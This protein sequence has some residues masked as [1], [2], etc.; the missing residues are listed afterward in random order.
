MDHLNFFNAPLS[1]SK[2]NSIMFYIQYF[3]RDSQIFS[4]KK[5]YKKY[6]LI[7]AINPS[8]IIFD[9]FIILALTV[10]RSK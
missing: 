4:L 10:L 8:L 9:L 3:I 2:S 5:F 1:I 6:L 7:T